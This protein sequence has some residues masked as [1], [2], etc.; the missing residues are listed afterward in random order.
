MSVTYEH[1]RRTIHTLLNHYTL[2]KKMHN[3]RP[4]H[5]V[6]DAVY[7]GERNEDT[8]WC[9][10]VARD[11]YEG[12]DLWWTFTTHET[13]AVY[14]QMHEELEALGYTILSVT[15]DGFGG[16]KQ[17]F[18]G[19]PYQM[20]HVHMERLVVKGTT[21]RPKLEAG[22]A[23]LALVH[24]LYDTDSHTFRMRVNEYLIRY[25]DFLNQKTYNSETGREE[26]THA[27]LLQAL[28]SLL[29]F[30][31][32]LFTFEHNR[33][34]PT[35]TNSLE[36]HFSHIRDVVN[37]HRGLSRVHKERVLHTLFVLGTIAPDDDLLKKLL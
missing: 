17:A 10:V 12:E 4:V 31:G 11:P 32:D 27:R 34:T 24:T 13:T 15:G 36:G 19:I 26:P 33:K 6:V 29:R 14:R 8:D 7:W 2:P 18:S 22:Q 5:L 28:K 16:I 35:H 20:C 23:L 21:R 37:V 3:P 1:D 9:S 25:R 30:R